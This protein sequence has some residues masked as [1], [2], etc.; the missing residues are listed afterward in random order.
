MRLPVICGMIRRR[1]LVNF[2]VDPDIVRRVLPAPFQPKLQ[3]GHAIAGI[4]L[5][6]LEQI[7]PRGLPAFLG[8]A[9]ENVAH[10][11][12]V[13]WNDEDGQ[14]REGVF[15]PQRHTNSIANRLAGGRL[16]PG[17][18]RL[19]R[20]QVRDSGERIAINVRGRHDRMRIDV[21]GRAADSLPAGSC[22][23]MFAAA[24]AFFEHGN[25]GYSAT[26]DCC[27]FD[28]MQLEAKSWRARPLAIDHVYS[29]YFADESLFPAGSVT[30]DHALVMRDIQHEWRSVEDMN[31]RVDQRQKCDGPALH[32]A[33][34]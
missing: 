32:S 24:S 33:S 30:F 16:F 17:D 15:I 4:C 18:Q 28:G 20:F 3:D 21:D 27:R 19:A 8:I 10:R 14:P 26:R 9:S 25:I 7:R 11:I 2:R 13:Q 23:S 29:S 5:I 1:L 34:R 22:F 6:R 12:A 31:V